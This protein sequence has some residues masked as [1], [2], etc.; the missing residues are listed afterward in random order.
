VVDDGSRDAVVTRT[1]REFPGVR[2]I[3]HA[4]AR[5]FCAAVNAGIAQASSTIVELL[6]DDAEATAGWAEAAL[7]CF[8]D[9][10]V[11]AVAPLVVQN[12]AVRRALGLAPLIDTAGDEYDRGGFARK[13]GHGKERGSFPLVRESVFGASACAAFYRRSAIIRA[14]GFTEDFGAYFEDVD[15]SFRLRNLGLEIVLEPRSVVWHH[16]S[17]SYSRRPPRRVLEQQSCNEERLFWRNARGTERVRLLPRH[18]AVLAAKAVRRLQE[19]TL[20]P[21]FLG[22]VRA[23]Y[24]SFSGKVG[25]IA[26]ARR[27]N[28]ADGLERTCP[29]SVSEP[30]IRGSETIRVTEPA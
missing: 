26:E 15:L 9:E 25:G 17:A 19:G 10:R 29:Q 5:G 13:R 4:R 24:S 27:G 20:L 3:R 2:S 1:A 7:E 11:A 30:R 22:R 14:G 8:A 6:N 23:I 18:A 21:W 12:D 16:L 28:S